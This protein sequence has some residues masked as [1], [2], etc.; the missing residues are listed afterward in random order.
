MIHTYALFYNKVKI[1][2]TAYNFDNFSNTKL[3]ILFFM[4]RS[5]YLFKKC[6]TCPTTGLKMRPLTI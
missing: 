2:E 4:V 6:L 3:E 5:N 1:I